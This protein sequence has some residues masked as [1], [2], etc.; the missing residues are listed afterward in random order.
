MPAAR[1]LRQRDGRNAQGERLAVRDRKDR[2]AISPEHGDR[3]KV[4]DLVHVTIERMA[5]TAPIHETVHGPRE[6]ACA[7]SPR[8]HRTQLCDVTQR[9]LV[10]PSPERQARSEGHE[11]LS[12][13]LD[14]TGDAREA[15]QEGYLLAQSARRRE[16]EATNA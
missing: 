13:P 8:V 3:W 2:V 7:S 9:K 15:Q 16:D 11:R 5:L 6:R 1:E 10:A 12:K 14:H 4:G